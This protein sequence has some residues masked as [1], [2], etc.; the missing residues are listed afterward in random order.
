MALIVESESL[1]RENAVALRCQGDLDAHTFEILDEAIMGLMEAGATHLL[2]D[3]TEVPYMSSAGIGV[4]IGSRS[5]A[6]EAGGKLVLLNPNNDIF[7]VLE[8]MGMT[9]VLDI[10]HSLEEA[11]QQLG[12]SGDGGGN[13]APEPPD[14]RGRRKGFD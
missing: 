14:A 1:G 6:E 12:L 13:A 5:E 7:D 11:L 9:N 10:A 8:S 3:L 2:I 4:I